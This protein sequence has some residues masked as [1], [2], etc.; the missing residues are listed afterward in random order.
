MS[1]MENY[2][3]LLADLSLGHVTKADGRMFISGTPTTLTEERLIERL[4]QIEYATVPPTPGR[5]TSLY[6]LTETGLNELKRHWPT[7]RG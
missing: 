3:S 5:N 4:V 1:P 2:L 6:A 7:W